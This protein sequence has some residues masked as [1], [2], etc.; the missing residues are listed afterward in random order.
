MG[1]TL[2]D[3]LFSEM[4]FDDTKQ[5]QCKLENKIMQINCF[6]ASAEVYG[7]EERLGQAD[8][9]QVTYLEITFSNCSGGPALFGTDFVKLL[10]D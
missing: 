8:A 3:A 7:Q 4:V 5:S 2:W 10:K 9:A 1:D 6:S